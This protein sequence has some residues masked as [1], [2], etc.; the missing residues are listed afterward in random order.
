MG[1]NKMNATTVSDGVFENIIIELNKLS[2]NNTALDVWLKC[3]ADP[4][5]ADYD[6]RTPLHL[7]YDKD[8]K[9]VHNV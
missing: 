3:G 5:A 1:I 6:K 2:G 9:K 8:N 7:A 4:N